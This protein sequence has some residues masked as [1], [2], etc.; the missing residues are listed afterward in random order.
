[1]KPEIAKVEFPVMMRMC[2]FGWVMYPA[3]DKFVGES[4]KAYGEYSPVETKF[5]QAV[6]NPGDIAVNAGAHIGSLAIMMARKVGVQG[7][8]IAFEPQ[9]FLWSLLK[10]NLAINSIKNVDAVYAAVGRECGVIEVPIVNYGL[11]NNFGGFGRASWKQVE[12]KRCAKVD[13][14]S[15]DS[16]E[17][18]RLDLLQA[19]VEAMEQ[20]VLEGAAKTIKKFRPRLFV[21]ND[22]PENFVGLVEYVKGLE[23][24]PY[25]VVTWL[26]VADSYY[27]KV[28]NVFP[29]VASFNMYCV[30]N[31]KP[32]WKVGGLRE[33]TLDDTPGNIP[34]EQV[35]GFVE[36]RDG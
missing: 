22:K 25:W 35:I 33:V 9:G 11:E 36:R 20:E 13:L 1:M 4:Y 34:A 30:P 17:L 6:L 5:L 8:V 21:E 10:A 12:S 27:G 24:T 2:R 18:P 14:I 7:K 29:G 16:L 31:E 3:T 28:E 26:H 32:E 23:Y 19:D 15:I